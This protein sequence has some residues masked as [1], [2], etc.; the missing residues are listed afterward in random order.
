MRERLEIFI[1]KIPLEKL[2]ARLVEQSDMTASESIYYLNTYINETRVALTLIERHLDKNKVILEVGA[3]L[4]FF[5]LFLRSEGYIVTA[6]EPFSGG[7]DLFSTAQKIV[8]EHYSYLKLS[9]INI[10]ADKLTKEHNGTFDLIFSNNVIE[11]MKPLTANLL[12]MK[13]VLDEKGL[14]V[15][16]CPNYVIPYEPHLQLP[17]IKRFPALTSYFFSKKVNQKKN[18]WESLNFIT[19]FDLC[20]FAKDN[21]LNMSGRKGVLY[22][23]FCRL[24]KDSYYR[25]RQSSKVFWYTYLFLKKTFLIYVLKY[26]PVAISTPMIV[27]MR[28][29][30]N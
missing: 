29:F 10:E 6:L 30:D 14:M 12:G 16:G 4:C 8:L 5:S 15:H 7:F 26:W 1:N 11:H 22:D 18:I 25:N 20:R 28:S 9:V 24:E 21:Q 23:A 2:V 27:E 13:T 3:G 19:Y 17:V